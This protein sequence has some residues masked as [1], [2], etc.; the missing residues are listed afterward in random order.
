MTFP[1]APAR[2]PADFAAALG[3]AVAGFG[4]LEEAL[5]RA[6]HALSRD[7]LGDDATEAEL[8][9]WIERMEDIADD[10][11][12]TLIDSFIAACHRCGADPERQELARTLTTIRERRNLLCH[13]SWKPGSTA[14]RWR[15]AFVSTRGEVFVGE[16]TLA[17]LRDTRALTLHAARAV[18]A[19]MRRTGRE[20]WW[21]GA[22]E[23]PPEEP[24][25]AAPHTPPPRPTPEAH[26][27]APAPRKSKHRRG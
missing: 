6:I 2:L 19:A 26:P 14:G 8:Q 1:R 11:L 15:P 23:A 3:H 7:R 13:A 27:P 25:P 16:I 22:G 20:G 17:Q 9:V 4:F 24:K 18:I 12:G 21:I 10:S 5:K